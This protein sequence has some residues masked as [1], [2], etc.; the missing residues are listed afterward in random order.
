[1][2][3]LGFVIA[4]VALFP[5]IICFIVAITKP[6]ALGTQGQNGDASGGGDG[7]GDCGGGGDGGGE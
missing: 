1:M 5:F 6:E 3:G 2:K 7:G 4:G